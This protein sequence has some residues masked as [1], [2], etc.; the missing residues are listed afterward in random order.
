MYM[1]IPYLLNLLF[2]GH[3]FDEV[4]SQY[5]GRWF[6]YPSAGLLPGYSADFTSKGK[7]VSSG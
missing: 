4:A 1:Y 6:E 3:K 2:I 7:S 5:I